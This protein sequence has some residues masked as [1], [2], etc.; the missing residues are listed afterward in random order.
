MNNAYRARP[1]CSVHTGADASFRSLRSEPIYLDLL[2]VVVV[3]H[4]E[5]EVV[6]EA[7]LI[8]HE[9][10]DMAPLMEHRHRVEGKSAAL[11]FVA[12]DDRRLIRTMYRYRGGYRGR[13]RGGYAPY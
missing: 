10:E 3:A 6:A 5:A 7:D 12:R 13:G 2:V 1:G 4:E 8:L 9:V 11:F